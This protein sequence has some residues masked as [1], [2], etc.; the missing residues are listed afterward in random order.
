LLET[1]MLLIALIRWWC[2]RP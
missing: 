2:F 1:V